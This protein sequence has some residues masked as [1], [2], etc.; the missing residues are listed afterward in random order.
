MRGKTRVG[1]LEARAAIRPENGASGL[2]SRAGLALATAA[3]LCL[4]L[5]ALWLSVNPSGP[6]L[7]PRARMVLPAAAPAQEQSQE[8]AQPQAQPATAAGALPA[9]PEARAAGLDPQGLTLLPE[10]EEGQVAP[11]GL[12]LLPPRDQG[13]A[14][15][16][17]IAPPVPARLHVAAPEAAGPMAARAVTVSMIGQ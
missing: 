8:Q 7:G 17:P 14:V 11:A 5:G 10:R 6:V 1:F 4:V 3:G 12:T 9:R 13:P 15:R 2:R 16:R